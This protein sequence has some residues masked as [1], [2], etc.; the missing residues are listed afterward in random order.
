MILVF[1]FHIAVPEEPQTDSSR[2]R[3][4][5]ATTPIQN[6]GT[7]GPSIPAQQT[8]FAVE[9]PNTPTQAHHTNPGPP[10]PPPPSHSLPQINS[11]PS[12]QQQHHQPQHH[13]HHHQQPYQV[14]YHQAPVSPDQIS[15]TIALT[16]LNRRTM[17][18]PVD[19]MPNGE[20]SL[21]N[22]ERYVHEDLS[23]SLH[24]Y[25]LWYEG[26]HGKVF[27]SNDR[28]LRN[29]VIYEAGRGNKYPK[30]ELEPRHTS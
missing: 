16:Q 5:S 15:L 11:G 10:L 14:D 24:S 6:S 21:S 20:Y 8:P 4:M 19:F 13:H 25:A 7:V 28:G 9:S 29:A 17:L 3:S 23:L 1:P 12:Y 26:P 18:S 30:W 27:I 2:E 22:V